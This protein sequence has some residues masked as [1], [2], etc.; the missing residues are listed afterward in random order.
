MQ[1]ATHFPSYAF[2]SVTGYFIHWELISS[3]RI[4]MEVFEGSDLVRQ[5]LLVCA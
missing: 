4:R 2:L 1:F 5:P 3:L